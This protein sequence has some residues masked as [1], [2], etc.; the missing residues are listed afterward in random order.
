[1][2]TEKAREHHEPMIIA[3]TLIDSKFNSMVPTVHDIPVGQILM[4]IVHGDITQEESDAIV[5][6]SN[7]FLEFTGGVSKGLVRNG[8]SVI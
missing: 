2:P 1:L 4:Q 7:P 6:S 3:S 5:S 8:G